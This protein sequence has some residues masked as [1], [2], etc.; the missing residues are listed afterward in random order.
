LL[1]TIGVLI[2][3]G[4]LLGAGA[5]GYVGYRW[6]Q[7]TKYDVRLEV[8][9]AGAPANYLL[10]G[11]DSRDNITEEDPDAGGFFGED[12][13][14]VRS[15]TIMVMRI[16]PR[17]TSAQLLSIPRDLWVP[18][19][20]GTGSSR[21]N[22]A[23][24]KGR[25]VLIDT[26]ESN[27]GITV[28]HYVEIDFVAFRDV[29]DEV[30]GVPL[31]FDQPVR[32]FGTGLFVDTP[33]CHVLDGSQ[34]LNF[35]RS[36]YLEHEVEPGVWRSDPTADLGRMTRQQIFVRRAVSKAVEDGFS[37]P[38]RLNGLLGSLLPKLGVDRNFDAGG[39]IDL[40]RQFRRFDPDDLVTH[41]LPTRDHMTSGGADV[42]LL[43]ERD[44]EPILNVFRGL[45]PGSVSPQFVE[46]EVRNGTG[47][48]GQAGDVAAALETIGFEVLG[49]DDSDE[50][51]ERTTVLYGEGGYEAARRV[52]LHVTGGAAL[53]PDESLSGTRVVLVTGVDLTTVHDQVAPPGSPDDLLSTT[54]TTVA[55]EP[56]P[57]EDPPGEDGDTLPEPE[58]DLGPTTT[59][60]VLGYATGEPP[61]DQ[62]C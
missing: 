4:S 37:N 10:V 15:D 61:A 1:V 6:S 22:T 5:M 32:D 30:G 46:V 44:A 28:N 55:P 34:A 18:M 60:T 17:E 58:P 23:Y 51:V 7:V 9:E 48:Q 59:T 25:Q 13:S 42:Q 29:V 11:S 24:G 33:G 16:D 62:E 45:P 8:A 52:A 47:A 14:G 41:T 43:V 38:R 36:R 56:P 21:I 3:L 2:V 19:A 27:L 50:H 40:A 20:D 53:V 39:L 35:A 12:I 54:T 31:W 57:D 49:V 26:I